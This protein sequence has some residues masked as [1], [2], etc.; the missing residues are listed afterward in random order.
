MDNAINNEFVSILVTLFI[1]LYALNLGKVTLPPYVRNLFKNTIFKILF[2]SLLL[3]YRFENS[4]HVA[5]TVAV[6][7]VLVLDFLDANEMKENFAY[8]ESF[9]SQMQ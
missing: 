7:F 9:K 2:L 1:V 5:L 4:P 3:I 8:L 6:V